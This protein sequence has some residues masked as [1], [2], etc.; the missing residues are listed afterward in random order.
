MRVIAIQF[1]G[2]R[3]DFLSSQNHLYELIEL[4]L[5][6]NANLVVTPEMS[7]S[8]YL[9]DHA[10][11][12]KA[13]AVDKDSAW[14][15]RLCTLIQNYQATLVVG[16]IEIDRQD[17]DYLYNSAAVIQ[18]DGHC[19]FYRK[20][21]LFDADYTW[22][23]NGNSQYPLASYDVNIDQTET[24]VTHNPIK[25]D[26]PVKTTDYP[27]FEVNGYRCTVGICMDLNDDHLIDFCI[28][29]QIEILAFPTNWLNEN[30]NVYNY[31]AYRLQDSQV[32]LVAANTYGK[33]NWPEY[34][35]A[36]RQVEF[37]GE[38]AII[39]VVNYQLLAVAPLLG[40][41]MIQADLPSKLDQN[42]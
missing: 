11:R 6:Q 14:I 21:L 16:V 30:H 38:S 22:A 10:T 20:R 17:G 39:D 27:I 40:D 19:F 4:A 24:S 23:Q 18:A 7:C 26:L 29:S 3:Q 25:Y 9:F 13:F 41:H 34:P 12:A 15:M 28:Q 31:W 8:Q 32:F 37:R 35:E 2:Y 5:Q 1:K 42:P 36:V 33:E